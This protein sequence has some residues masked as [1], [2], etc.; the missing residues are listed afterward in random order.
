MSRR[1]PILLSGAGRS[2]TTLIYRMLSNHPDVGFFNNWTNA[3][4]RLSWLALLN[5]LRLG[6]VEQRAI[7]FRGYPSA[8]EAYGIWTHVFP[9]FW[10]VNHQP[11][12]DGPATEYLR[13]LVDRHLRWHGVDRFLTKVTGQPIFD[14]FASI[15]PGAH[16]V[17][18]AR[19]PRAVAYRMFEKSTAVPLSRC[20]PS[21]G[22][23]GFLSRRWVPVPDHILTRHDR[24]VLAAWRVKSFEHELARTSA[25]F[26]RI[27]YERIVDQPVDSLR[28]LCDQL[29]LEWSPRFERLV[30]GWPMHKGTNRAWRS[31]LASEEVETLESLLYEESNAH[32]QLC[33]S[34]VA[35][36]DRDRFG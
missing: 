5:R 11:V 15:F 2:G 22:S 6:M 23:D 19:D 25:P 10:A 16:G 18:I 9:H 24:L 30:A 33:A 28:G 20:S 14:F 34:A 29:G 31:N 4:P 26:N 13:S 21:S 1:N 35:S 27:S 7:R 17:W 12:E 32:Q 8:A 36:Q 3:Y